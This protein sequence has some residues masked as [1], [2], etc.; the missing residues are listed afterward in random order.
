VSEQSRATLEDVSAVRKRLAIEVPADEVKREMDR[1]YE[2]VRRH[3]KLRGFRQGRAPRSVLER[4]YGDQV[5]RDVMARLVETS[6]RRAIEDHA[7]AV[8]GS[9]EIDADRI[10][11]SAPFRYTATVDVPPTFELVDLAAITAERRPAAVT[12]DEV[13][14]VLA[15]LRDR[16]ASLRP[17][18]D[19]R[20]VEA[21]D[22][23]TVDIT[24]R[25]GDA[26]PQTRSDVMLEAG[27]GAFDAA[28]ENALV[29]G[30][31]GVTA[32]LAVTYPDEYGNAGLAGQ[33]VAFTVV[34]KA[35]HAKE[36]PALDDEFAK[37]HGNAES[38][39]DLRAKI[40]ADL[41]AHAREE[42][43]NAMRETV[44]DALVERHRFEAPPSVVER[45]ADTMLAS[46]GVRMPDGPE[47]ADLLERLRGEV[48]P[49]AERDV[50]IDFILDALAERERLTVSE[51]DVDAAIEAQAAHDRQPDRVRTLYA[52][53]EARQMLRVRLLRTR[54]FEHVLGVATIADVPPEPRVAPS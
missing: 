17:L 12:D 36:L 41:E 13:E 47:G 28:L 4:F 19:R 54:A 9:P 26:A 23:V 39:G 35:L 50:R 22:V 29:G 37:D 21:G 3:A 49:R 46:Y 40:R 16:A 8:V 51:E 48:R 44:L 30:E 32:E 52:R 2:S 38:L 7:L 33:T 53:D 27:S 15:R 42:A 43:E 20:V 10:E 5:R 24:S 25:L 1:A 31:V 34:P 45:R 11:A 6:F 18:E 14:R